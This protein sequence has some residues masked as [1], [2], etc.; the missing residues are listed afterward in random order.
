MHLYA[1]EVFICL[2]GWLWF[3]R[4]EVVREEVMF[5]I[6]CAEQTQAPE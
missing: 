1:G 2:V 6:S 5:C 4:T 3:R